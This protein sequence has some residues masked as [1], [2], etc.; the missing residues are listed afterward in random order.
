ME[1]T[2]EQSKS[3]IGTVPL[4][5]YVQ[6]STLRLKLS[7]IRY[8]MLTSTELR[9]YLHHMPDNYLIVSDSRDSLCNMV[10]KLDELLGVVKL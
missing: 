7:D 6:L 10:E 1:T 8:Y 3:Y 2:N 9:I 5:V 4:P